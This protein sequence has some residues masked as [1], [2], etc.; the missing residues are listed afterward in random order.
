MAFSLDNDTN[1]AELYLDGDKNVLNITYKKPCDL[2]TIGAL[3]PNGNFGFKGEIEDIRLGETLIPYQKKEESIFYFFK[4]HLNTIKIN[5]KNIDSD[6]NSLKSIL[7]QINS[8]KIRGLT[9]DTNLLENQ[10]ENFENKK[11]IFIENFTSEY[12]KLNEIDHKIRNSEDTPVN[13]NIFDSYQIILENLLD[14]ISILDEAVDNLSEFESLGIH[15]GT[16][17]DSIDKQKEYIKDTIINAEKYLKQSIDE[18]FEIM[19]IITLYE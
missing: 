2:V 12:N 9:I 1:T 11:A 17:F 10:I 4:Q 6:I 16:A 14:D 8:W 18:T 7:D 3:M 15:L 13:N 5:L 19:N